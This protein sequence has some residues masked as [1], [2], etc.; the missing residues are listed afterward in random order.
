V[1]AV[2]AVAAASWHVAA[3]STVIIKL[4]LA[5]RNQRRSVWYG[6]NILAA[7]AGEIS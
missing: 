7:M 6:S 3:S 2:A 1:A 5:W 4:K